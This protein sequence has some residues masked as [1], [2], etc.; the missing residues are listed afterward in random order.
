MQSSAAC[1][2]SKDTEPT[3]GPDVPEGPPLPPRGT[4]L[5]GA[6]D[7][8][9]ASTTGEILL[10]CEQQQQRHDKLNHREKVTAA[11]NT[12]ITNAPLSRRPCASNTSC[13]G[14]GQMK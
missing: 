9:G 14:S 10:G 5:D 8:V 12:V 7:V 2:K 1:R 3:G 11:R 6:E 13:T 4:V